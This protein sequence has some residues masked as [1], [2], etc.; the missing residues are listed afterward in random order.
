MNQWNAQNVYKKTGK[1][2]NGNV[3]PISSK[4]LK[5]KMKKMCQSQISTPS[6]Q[7]LIPNL[8]Q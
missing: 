2:T 8:Y 1:A 5:V 7:E 6:T 3:E 4:N